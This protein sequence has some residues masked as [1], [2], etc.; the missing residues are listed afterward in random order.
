[1][2][3]HLIMWELI[4]QNRRKSFILFIMMGICLLLLGFLLGEA[5]WG[6]GGGVAGL[7]L[8]FIIWA[9]LSLVSYFSGDSIM[10]NIAG[11]KEV[12][13]DVHPQLF[14]VVEEMKIAASLPA[15]PKVYIIDTPAPNAFATGRKP[16]KCAIAVTA[17]LLTRLNRD[18]L[19]GVVAHEMSHI[20]NRDI[21]FMT[22]A[23]IMLGSIMLLSRIFLYSGRGRGSRRIDSR[24]S[25]GGGGVPIV[26]I[27]A[28]I[29]AILAPILA[30]FLYM[31]ISRQREYLADAS[32]VRLT[33]YPE[34]LASAL[35]KISR[36]SDD[37][38][39]V[40]KVT[41]PLYISNPL[42]AKGK[43]ATD[44]GSTHPPI[45]ERI[46]IL[47]AMSHSVDLNEYQKAYQKVTGKADKLIPASGLKDAAAIPI[48]GGATVA[49]EP[50]RPGSKAGTRQLNDLM[51]AVNNYLF[52]SCVCGLRFKLPPDFKRKDFSCP[53]CQ[54][55]IIVPTAQL[56]AAAVV[57]DQLEAKDKIVADASKA[58]P[59]TTYRRTG[60]GWETLSCPSCN[61]RLQLSPAFEG[62]SLKCGKCGT[63]IRIEK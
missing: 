57:L 54:R 56:A 26:A 16:E 31:A 21:L 20:A 55:K 24:K 42:R 38:P 8:A 22:F 25:S 45:E 35:D 47:R 34:G 14:N 13:P 29:F 62:D 17:G 53:R 58:S 12:T 30:H 59:G 52:V 39:N 23:G 19:Q 2:T 18:E 43:Q 33:R 49:A 3:E 9:I 36:S 44:L 27:I 60:T 41:A 7:S 37:M 61:H 50:P 48:L 11:A 4:R 46:R 51:R 32:A 40:N 5:F 28:I 1:M 15:M 6:E 10:L 63:M